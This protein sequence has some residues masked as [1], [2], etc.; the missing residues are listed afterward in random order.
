VEWEEHL[1]K[2]KRLTRRRIKT[3]KSVNGLSVLGL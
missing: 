2:V 3:Y 1:E